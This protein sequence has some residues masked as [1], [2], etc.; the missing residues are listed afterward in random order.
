MLDVK[1]DDDAVRNAIIAALDAESMN[2]H[3][4]Y[5]ARNASHARALVGSSARFKRLAMPVRPEDLADYPSTGL[6]G[7]RL[8]EDQVDDTTLDRIRGTGLEAWVTAGIRT[9]G[10]ASGFITAERLRALERLGVAAVLVNDVALARTAL[11]DPHH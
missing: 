6:I 9:Q 3:V 7:A 2:D 4:V 10:E 1:L 11:N 5:G 8:W